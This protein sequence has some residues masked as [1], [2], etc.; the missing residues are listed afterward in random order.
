VQKIKTESPE[1]VSFNQSG[2]ALPSL[3]ELDELELESVV[4]GSCGTNC[5]TFTIVVN[6]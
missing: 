4:G 6:K 3:I 1:I 5:G 2:P